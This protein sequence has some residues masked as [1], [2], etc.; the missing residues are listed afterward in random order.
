M[1]AVNYT[2]SQIQTIM[3]M[4]QKFNIESTN[5]TPNYHQIANAVFEKIYDNIHSSQSA[6]IGNDVSFLRNKN[7]DTF[8]SCAMR[9]YDHSRAKT[10]IEKGIAIH[11]KDRKGNLPIHH[12]AKQGIRW[13]FTVIGSH[14][15]LN[16]PNNNGKT[17][18]H[19]AAS[20]NQTLGLRRENDQ[21]TA[22]YTFTKPEYGTLTGT[23]W[24]LPPIFIA[25]IKGKYN[26][27][28][29]LL[30]GTSPELNARQLKPDHRAIDLYTFALENNLLINF[31]SHMPLQLIKKTAN[32]KDLIAKAESLGKSN[33]V[34]RLNIISLINISGSD[35]NE[36]VANFVNAYQRDKTFAA[37]FLKNPNSWVGT[38][39][40]LEFLSGYSQVYSSEFKEMARIYEE[41]NVPIS[42]TVQQKLNPSQKTNLT[43]TKNSTSSKICSFVKS[44]FT[45]KVLLG[46]TFVV[47]GLAAFYFTMMTPLA[48]TNYN[49]TKAVVLSL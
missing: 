49:I 44:I 47:A 34:D 2:G 27:V 18:G 4:A 25:L 17:A 9:K 38:Y 8:I 16:E 12:I 42:K 45:S 46:I 20:N 33:V 21:L 11:E 14:N 36:I 15:Y 10:F 35:T 23:T 39:T 13:L 28:R 48:L 3:N 41:L 19:K 1:S 30:E 40:P 5:A 22:T 7:G 37:A 31:M 24:Q 43:Q 26:A 6:S 29:W 32:L